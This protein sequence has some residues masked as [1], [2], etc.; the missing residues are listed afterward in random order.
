[1]QM[2][3]RDVLPAEAANLVESGK[4]DTS[5][6][7]GWRGIPIY[8]LG[9]LPNAF[10]HTQNHCFTIAMRLDLRLW[11]LVLLSFCIQLGMM[12]LLALYF[13]RVSLSGP[14]SNV[15]A[16]LLTTLIV[17]LGFVSLVA[18]YVWGALAAAIAKTTDLLVAA[19]LSSMGWF[20]RLLRM[21]WRIPGPPHWLLSVFMAIL[22]C[23]AALAWSA[24][25]QVQRNRAATGNVRKRRA[26][27]WLTLAAL[28]SSVVVVAIY[29]FHPGLARR[30]L[31]A[32]VLDVG[33]GDSI[34]VAFP[35]GRTMLIDDGGAA[36]AERVGGY[37]S[38]IDVGGQVVWPY[39]WSEASRNSTWCCSAVR[40]TI[41]LTASARSSMNFRVGQLWVGRDENAPA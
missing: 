8:W 1:M 29:P 32:A 14:V 27:E 30:K 39:L 7:L 17:P 21:S 31:Q 22:A 10:P 25:R 23:L 4:I 40:V 5:Q 20:S 36:G 6:A 37:Q 41:T 38:G 2:Q 11:E 13:H 16:V 18:T 28:L 33:Q 3:Q 24:A 9:N 19:L 35:D 15:P 12:P 34:F 26:P